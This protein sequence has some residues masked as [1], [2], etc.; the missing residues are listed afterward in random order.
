MNNPE[1]WEMLGLQALHRSDYLFAAEMLAKAAAVSPIKRRLLHALAEVYC[2]L[3]QQERALPLAEKVP[4]AVS[5]LSPR[6]YTSVSP[7]VPPC[8]MCDVQALSLQPDSAVLRNLVLHLAPDTYAER[9]RNMGLSDRVK[10][11]GSILK[12]MERQDKREINEAEHQ[13]SR[14]IE[15]L[16]SDEGTCTCT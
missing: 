16:D 6:V 14:L 4:N 2:A 1:L 8:V 3:G 9:L 15:A 12:R 5:L 11:T 10:A 7:D 13:M